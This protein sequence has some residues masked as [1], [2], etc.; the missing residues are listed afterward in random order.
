M[1]DGVGMSTD[2]TLARYFDTTRKIIWAWA[3][4]PDNKFPSPYKVGPNMTRWSNAEIK[5]H[6]DNELL[7][8]LY[9]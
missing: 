7:G 2:V 5:A 1:I 9:A 4:D 8:A 6:R 3:R